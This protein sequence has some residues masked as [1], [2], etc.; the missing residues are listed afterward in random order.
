[1]VDAKPARSSWHRAFVAYLAC[2]TALF[3][4]LPSAEAAGDGFSEP[5]S[6]MGT[7]GLIEMP[8]ARMAPDGTFSTGAAY[9]R[10]IQRYNI[11]FQVLPWLEGNFRYSGISHTNP[12]FPVYWDRSF[13]L[14]ARFWDE[15]DVFPAL[16]AGINDIVGTGIYSSEYVVASKRFGPFDASFGVGWGRYG[17]A[18]TI[19]NPFAQLM[20]SF[21]NRGDALSTPGGLGAFSKIFHGSTAGLFGGVIWNTPLDG[22]S[23]IVESSSDGYVDEQ[24]G[25]SFTGTKNIF[26]PHTQM[27]FGLSY[28]AADSVT[29]N[30]AWLYGRTIGASVVFAL[31]PTNDPFPQHFGDPPMPDIHLRSQAEQ[32]QALNNLFEQRQ[33]SRGALLF[34][35]SGMNALSDALFAETDGIT[36]VSMRG[37]TL[38][39]SLA[40]GDVRAVCTGAAAMVARYNLDLDAVTATDTVGRS[41]RCAVEKRNSNAL[42]NASLAR[43]PMAAAPMLIPAAVITI[44]ASAPPP[45]SSQSA[46]A[47]IKADAAKQ[48]VVIQAI[49]LTGSEAIVY[50]SN[51]RYLNEADAVHRLV[52]VLMKDAPPNIEKFR[53]L[54]TL[55]GIP[56]AEFDIL[57]A[58]SERAI[59]QTGS[60]SLLEDG[61]SLT[62]APLQNPVLSQGLKGTYPRFGWSIFPQFRQELFDPQNPFA[63][64][65]LGGVQ[66]VAEIE[67]GLAMIGEAEASVYDNF[68]VNRVSDSPLAHVRTDWTRFFTE[69]KNG[70]GQAELDYMTRLAPDVYAQ[71]R[72]G[73]LESMFAG[74]GGEILWRPE[75]QRWAI[76]ADIF[77]VRQRNFDRLFGFQNYAVTTGHVTL[78]YDSPWYD[79]NFQ[80]RAGQYLA[81]DRGFTFEMSRRFSTGVEFGVFFTK[82]NVSAAQFGEGSFDKG[83]IV[84]IPL[85]WVLPVSTQNVLSTIVRPI[86]R[87]GGQA[88]ENDAN[89]YDYLRRT[90]TATVLDHAQDFA[91]GE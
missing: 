19:P 52:H 86:Q 17:T 91:A 57:R 67:P 27:N 14:K 83:F 81:G 8:S 77:R 11:N 31:D 66:G 5:R 60:Y 61:N 18:N 30:L 80:L 22:L 79:V 38:M 69:G 40:K 62:D 43:N 12:E 78:Y 41:A 37:R 70:I 51:L 34:S 73:Y 7:P 28:R 49:S 26:A 13:G 53:L 58:P 6:T 89:L 76:G 68:N 2:T 33:G 46:L 4:A 84:R 10:D 71:A 29:L 39:L 85:D 64:Q 74:G 32:L 1:M 63:V 25:T 48:D 24:A 87:D 15:T 50:Y 82:T 23:L 35:A 20:P 75:G 55:S 9:Q 56:Q 42:V 59:A 44:D 3:L 36:D 47:A 65:L 45:P 16:S 21:A 88:L 72:I 54:P 90:G